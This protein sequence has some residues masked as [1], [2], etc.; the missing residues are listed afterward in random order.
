MNE[1]NMQN[2]SKKIIKISSLVMWAGAVISSPF[3]ANTFQTTRTEALENYRFNERSSNSNFEGTIKEIDYINPLDGETWVAVISS[4]TNKIDA[5]VDD[6]KVGVHNKARYEKGIGS[7]YT[8]ISQD[9]VQL[10]PTLTNLQIEQGIFGEWS[11]IMPGTNDL[12]FAW[13]GVLGYGGGEYM[14]PIWTYHTSQQSAMEIMIFD[15]SSGELLSQ[16]DYWNKSFRYSPSF[17]FQLIRSEGNNNPDRKF[18]NKD[19]IYSFTEIPVEGLGVPVSHPTT[20]GEMD[21]VVDFREP[22]IHDNFWEGQPK[23]LEYH[24]MRRWLSDYDNEY[25]IEF[26][27]FSNPVNFYTKNIEATKNGSDVEPILKQINVAGDYN[28]KITEA[29]TTEGLNTKFT[30]TMDI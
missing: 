8:G 12:S 30:L 28:T 19:K 20:W 6:I 11:R 3:I 7:D 4:T 16:S 21:L 18:L 14:A 26:D 17:K 25:N 5:R 23:H 10:I 13:E 2:N 27:L 29:K 15:I 1:K 9:T 22:Y 24:D